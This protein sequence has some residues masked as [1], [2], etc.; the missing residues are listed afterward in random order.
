MTSASTTGFRSWRP[1]SS[2]GV[3]VQAALHLGRIEAHLTNRPKARTRH[4][5]ALRPAELTLGGAK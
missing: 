5:A 2:Y 4:F 1:T 3:R